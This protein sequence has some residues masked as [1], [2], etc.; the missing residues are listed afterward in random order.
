MGDAWGT[1]VLVGGGVAILVLIVGASLAVLAV[2]SALGLTS[3][4][5]AHLLRRRDRGGRDEKDD[6]N[7]DG[8]IDDLF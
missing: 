8:G 6:P 4:S 2:L 1:G 5:V 7:D 3:Y